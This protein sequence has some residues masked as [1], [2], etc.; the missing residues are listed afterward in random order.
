MNVNKYKWIKHW[1]GNWNVLNSS[2]LGYQYTKLLNETF[3][4]D[5]QYA[6]FI[7]KKGLTV[8]YLERESYKK[9]GDKLAQIIEEDHSKAEEWSDDLKQKTDNILNFI[10]NYRDKEISK[11]KYHEFVKLFWEYGV[12]HRAVKIVVDYLSAET[13]K[14]LLPELSKA[15]IYAEP[16]YKNTEKFIE[17]LCKAVSKKNG[18]KFENILAMTKDE[19][20]QYFENGNLP[21][22]KVLAE[23][24][25]ANVIIYVNGE[26]EI[27]TGSEVKEIET[28]IAKAYEGEGI[29]NGTTAYPGK[30]KGKIRIVFKPEDID[31]FKE[32]DILLT[33]MTRP[34]YLN[35]VKKSGAFITD[36]GGMLS[37]A[38]ITAREL[39][40]PCIVGT[41]VATKVLKDGDE[42]EVDADNGIIKKI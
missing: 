13:L 26:Y 42:V 12:P 4:F 20:D 3:G 23:R 33:G 1:A 36:A 10:N 14:K 24:Y 30:A 19:I 35:L 38:A 16:V 34:E 29:V 40:K 22:E 18:Y 6:L 11:E 25:L 37:H 5:L 32:G 41:E 2:L 17:G 7:Y 8:A 39:K 28:N 27:I 21:E 9:F 31:D 15:R